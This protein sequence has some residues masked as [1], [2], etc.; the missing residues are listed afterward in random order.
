MKPLDAPALATALH[1]V[2]SALADA[3]ALPE[4]VVICGGAALLGLGFITRRTKDVDVLAGVDPERGLIDPRP[5]SPALQTAVAETAKA[6][7]LPAN[8]FNA[9]PADQVLAGLPEGFLSR[10][11][12]RE[13]GTHRIV[14]FPDRFDL[15]HLKLF[16]GVD[17]GPGHHWTD[18]QALQPT[19]EEMLSAARWVLGQ[20]AGQ[21]FPDLVRR[22]LKLH[23]YADIADPI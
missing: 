2:S 22:A 6:L 8:W 9:G 12:R 19:K 13:F 1:A 10:L 17:Q 20:D 21:V 11:Q 16:A 4:T 18:L 5:F 7:G 3:Q 15:I 14:F 23:G